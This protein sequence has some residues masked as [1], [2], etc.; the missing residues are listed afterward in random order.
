MGKIPGLAGGLLLL[1][2]FLAGCSNTAKGPTQGGLAVIK[3]SVPS[4]SPHGQIPA[5]FTCDGRNVSLP[6]KWGAVP[7][8][9]REMVL[10]VAN[11]TFVKGRPKLEFVNWGVA[12]VNP[13]AHTITAGTLP[14]GSVVAR[15]GYRRADYSIC[16]SRAHLTRNYAIQLFALSQNVTVKRG[17]NVE[18]LMKKLEEESVIKGYGQ[19]LA[20]YQGHAKKS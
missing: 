3:L 15:N 9:T 7:A 4:L 2:L 10:V 18:H 1:G 16:P 14:P 12:G 20:T 6:L 19:L 17:F 8:G 5:E 11:Y 13:A